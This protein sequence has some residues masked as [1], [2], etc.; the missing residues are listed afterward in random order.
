MAPAGTTTRRSAAAGTRTRSAANGAGDGR[1]PRHEDRRR[2][3]RGRLPLLASVA[4][5]AALLVA[6]AAC[7]RA[8]R[9]ESAAVFPKAPVVLVSIDTLRSDR[10]PAYGYSKVKTPHLDRLAAD[11]W[12]FAS[13]WAPTPMTLPSHASMLTGMLP[14][15]HGVR[16]NSGFTLRGEGLPSLPRLLKAE[17]YATGA[18]VSTFVLR[19]ETGLGALFD[20][21]EDSVPTTPGVAT[22]RYQRPGEKTLAFAKEWV[23]AHAGGPFFYFFHV[24]EPHLPYEPAPEFLA[25]Y[26]ATYEA[27]IA[28][29]DAVV[30]ALLEHLRTLGLYE[31]AIVIVTSDHGEGLGD[32]GEEQHSLLLY[33]EAIQV[34]LFLKLPG[35]RGGGT[36]VD[37]PVQLSDLLPTVT[38]LLGLATPAGVSGRS[39]LAAAA[40]GSAPRTIYGET[41]YPRLHLGWADLRSVVDGRWHYVHGPRPELYDLAADPAERNDL[42]ASERARAARLARELLRFP[43]GNERPAAE[44]E[45]TLRRLAALG[46]LGGLRARPEDGP[47]PNPVD[48]VATL[49]RMETGWRLAS[50]GRT[51]EAIAH[52]AALVAEQPGMQEAWVK[53]AEL[54]VEAGRDEEAAAT[55][56]RVLSSSPVPLPDL[57]IALASVE[58]G[59]GRNDEAEALARSALAA[60]PGKAHL[61]LCRV[62]LARGDLAAAEREAAEAVAATGEHPAA[63]L[64]LAE[65]KARA[66][67]TEEALRGVER[68]SARAREL[69]VAP[70]WNLEFVRGDALARANR[71]EEAE[72]AFRAEIAAFPRNSQAFSS[73]AVLRFLRRD[74]AEVGRLLEAMYGAAPSG[75]TA[76]LAARTLDSLGAKPEAAAWRKRAV[77]AR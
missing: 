20:A 60:L 72:A 52:L 32:H 39:L 48:N 67:R 74:T 43:K 24:F 8:T 57:T 55:Y 31:K 14:P 45:E 12:R 59:R 11:S 50:E 42:V 28:T 9:P 51:K 18:A 4:L 21:Y 66:G 58:L 16:G 61:L 47:L 65:T 40:P 13:A 63:L 53:L 10:L 3:A 7:R 25:E 36:V 77:P 15:E 41:L 33:R 76:L 26:G 6:S 54:R 1:S 38:G 44:D 22:V 69:R 19:R 5:T 23:S 71:L 46:Y 34:P 27:E 75:K 68:A 73:L 70:V 17:G 56:R 64:A 35:S 2:R 30:G 29:A 37:A 49:R 62:A